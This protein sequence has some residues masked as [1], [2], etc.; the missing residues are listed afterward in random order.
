MY[1]NSVLSPNPTLT[2]NIVDMHVIEQAFS[3]LG[4]SFAHNSGVLTVVELESVLNKTFQLAQKGRTGLIEPESCAELTLNWM[5]KCYDRF[6]WSN[7]TRILS[8]RPNSSHGPTCSVESCQ[9][10]NHAHFSF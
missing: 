8:F 3:E 5:L 9:I 7:R 4:L 10:G 2:V 6:V 1:L